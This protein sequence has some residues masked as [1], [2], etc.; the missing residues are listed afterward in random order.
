MSIGKN[1]I[2][3]L[4]FKNGYQFHKYLPKHNAQIM[5]FLG[6]ENIHNYLFVKYQ[7]LVIVESK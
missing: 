5:S 3:C 7:L 2:K 6:I 4:Y 1:Y